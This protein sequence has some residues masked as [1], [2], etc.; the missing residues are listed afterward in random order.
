MLVLLGY[1]KLDGIYENLSNQ[2]AVIFPQVK[3][4]L[5]LEYDCNIYSNKIFLST[6]Q[7]CQIINYKNM[8]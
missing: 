3:N 6:H 4:V 5:H 8:H 2:V 7:Y 1:N